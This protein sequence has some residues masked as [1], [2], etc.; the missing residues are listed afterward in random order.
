MVVVRNGH[1]IEELDFRHKRQVCL[2][3]NLSDDISQVQSPSHY[4]CH[5]IPCY[6]YHRKSCIVITGFSIT[7]TLA[8]MFLVL[9]MPAIG[10]VCAIRLELRSRSATRSYS[11]KIF[12]E[13][14][15]AAVLRNHC[16]SLIMDSGGVNS[17]T[18]N[19]NTIIN[20]TKEL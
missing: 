10:T 1:S 13:R 17:T 15:S 3:C 20:P 19:Y 6:V 7:C 11:I 9:R 2:L 16:V 12:S 8:A 14:D 4:Q 5:Q 18:S